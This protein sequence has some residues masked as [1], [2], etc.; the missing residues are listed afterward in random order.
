MSY[1]QYL[2]SS[3]QIPKTEYEHM[4][5]LLGLSKNHKGEKYN[6]I[7]AIYHQQIDVLTRECQRKQAELD[8]FKQAMLWIDTTDPELTAGAEKKFDI[9]IF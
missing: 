1:T 3:I 8:K 6:A 7:A 2:D 9:K 5:E 4:L